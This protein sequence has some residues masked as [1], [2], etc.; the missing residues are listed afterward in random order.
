MNRLLVCVLLLPIYFYVDPS[1]GN[2]ASFP[3]QFLGLETSCDD[4]LAIYSFT[5]NCTAS[6][7]L[8]VLPELELYWL[9]NGTMRTSNSMIYNTTIN[10]SL[11]LLNVLSFPS[12][13]PE[14]TGMYTC[15]ARIVIPDSDNITETDNSTVVI[16]G[17]M[18]MFMY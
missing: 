3:N 9:H 18:I 11:Y 17:M 4:S 13:T 8:I 14:D 15:M 5:L 10:G 1:I 6:K 16:R 12:S 2:F 7:P